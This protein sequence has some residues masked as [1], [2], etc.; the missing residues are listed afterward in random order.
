MGSY[1]IARRWLWHGIWA[2]VLVHVVV[3]V[4]SEQLFG[5]EVI[6]QAALGSSFLVH[7]I[8]ILEM[9]DYYGQHRLCRN[10]LN[11]MRRH[12]CFMKKDQHAVG[13][14]DVFAHSLD[15]VF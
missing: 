14:N 2:A 6:P 12:H 8:K 1:E 13:C 11:P 3:F 5:I 7:R 4:V 10:L 15:G 9:K